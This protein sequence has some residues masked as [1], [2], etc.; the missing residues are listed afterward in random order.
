MSGAAADDKGLASWVDSARPASGFSLHALRMRAERAL[1]PCAATVSVITNDG[2]NIIGVLRG[3]DQTTN[4]ILD[5]CHERVY[6][7]K[8]RGRGAGRSG[9]GATAQRRGACSHAR[10]AHV[11]ERNACAARR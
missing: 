1:S 7:T 10:V 3:Y 11:C 5:E 8:A 6:S 2:R 9:S 4:L